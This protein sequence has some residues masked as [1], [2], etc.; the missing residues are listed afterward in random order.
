MVLNYIPEAIWSQ[1]YISVIIYTTENQKEPFTIGDTRADVCVYNIGI[2]SQIY[3][4][5]SL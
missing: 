1:F 4:G 3:L 5:P 2:M